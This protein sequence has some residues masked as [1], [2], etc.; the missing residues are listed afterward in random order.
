MGRISKKILGVAMALGIAGPAAAAEKVVVGS[1]NFP[2]Q[3]IL[4]HIY[5]N[6]LEARDVEVNKRMNLGSREIVFP[7][8]ESGELDLLPE[9]TGALLAHLTEGKS[10]VYKEEAVIE[11]LRDKL[12]EGIVMLEPAGAQNKDALVVTQET[13]DKHNLEAVSD[14]KGK[15]GDMIV[16][17]PP[18]METRRV[19][20]PGLKEVYGIEFG[21]FRSLDAGGPL[22]AGALQNGDIDVARM[23]TTQG[24]IDQ[25]GWVVLEDDKDLVPAQNLVPVAR[26][27]VLNDKI[28]SALTEVSANLTT[29]GLQDMNRRVSVD[30]VSPEQLAQEWV[31][32]HDLGE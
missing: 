24:M 6:V 22:T 16:G 12:P 2:E 30:K 26:E 4:A 20:V 14:L 31:Q 28:R 18:E 19:G 21:E 1:T 29:Q 8:L 10:G 32:E 5:A 11:A 23:F 9:Y 25:R 17:G 13:A 27:E 15:A 3:L 7:A